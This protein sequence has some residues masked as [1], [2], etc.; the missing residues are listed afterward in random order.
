MGYGIVEADRSKP[1]ILS[2]AARIRIAG[3]LAA[4]IVLALIALGGRCMSPT[5]A[6]C[7]ATTLF[8]GGPRLDVPYLGTRPAVVAQM[9]EMARVGP[10]DYVIDLGT[11]DGRI[12][13]AAARERSARGLGIDIDPVM[14]GKAQT[15]AE[16]AGVA[17]RVRFETADLFKADL[18]DADVVTMFLLPE[19]NL[20]LRPRLL[21]QLKPGTRIVSHAFDMGDWRPDE[22]RRV[23]GAVIHLWRVPERG[24]LPAEQ[25]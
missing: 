1:N 12:L 20:R 7:S 8:T 4:V 2:S 22:T 25:R 16:S 15:N 14:V 9:L 17:D 3:A 10:G 23:G 24:A 13:I 6:S 21:A 18:A 19:V 11:G 5:M